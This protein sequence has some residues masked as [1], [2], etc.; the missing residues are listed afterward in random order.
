MK[1]FK[2]ILLIF[3]C[4]FAFCGC[5]NEKKEDKDKNTT[6]IVADFELDKSFSFMDFEVTVKSNVSILTI[7]RELSA[8][9]NR[10]V[11]RVPVTVRNTGSKNN[12]ISMF[13]YKFYNS[14]EMELGSKGAYYND[15]LDYAKDLAP[16]EKYDKFFYIS[17]EGPGKYIIEFNNFSKKF[18]VIVNVQE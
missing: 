14:N 6:E 15:S 12:H 18:K 8:D 16:G 10:K 13:Y 11:V 4:I 1:R 5:T 7:K 17:Y 3:I 2:Y 9:N